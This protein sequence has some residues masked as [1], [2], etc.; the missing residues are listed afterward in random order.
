MAPAAAAPAGSR[1]GPRPY[2]SPLH[3]DVFRSRNGCP[4]ARCLLRFDARAAV[5]RLVKR[6]GQGWGCC[7]T[8]AHASSR[9]RQPVLVGGGVFA[10]FL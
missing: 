6:C 1:A 2:R 5:Q 3:L 4:S 8:V 10:A 9:T 7:F